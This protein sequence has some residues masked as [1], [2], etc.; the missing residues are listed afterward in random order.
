METANDKGFKTH[1]DLLPKGL[2]PAFLM[3]HMLTHSLE[4]RVWDQRQDAGD[5]FFWCAKTCTCVGPDDELVEPRRCLPGR[6]CYDG[7]RA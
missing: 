2:C 7:P 3:K 4:D 6:S 1:A 5:G